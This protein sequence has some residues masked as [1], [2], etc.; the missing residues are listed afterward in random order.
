V[1]VISV[2]HGPN[3]SLLGTREVSIYGKETLADIDRALIDLGKELGHEVE[4]FQSNHEGALI[5]RIHAARGRAS[6]IVLNAAGYTHTSVA[7][8]DAVLAVQDAAFTIEVH[9]SNPSAREDFRRT[10]LLMDVV[11]GRI[12]GFG[13]LSYLLALR[14]ASALLAPR[15]EL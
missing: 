8:R 9:L 12:E 14:A 10:N 4:C 7:L 2:I 15:G 3:L 13:S 5:D 1:A 11:R 6:A